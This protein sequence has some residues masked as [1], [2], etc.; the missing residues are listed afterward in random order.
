MTSD[1]AQHDAVGAFDTSAFS[2]P[3]DSIWEESM[4]LAR[5]AADYGAPPAGP[6]TSHVNCGERSMRERRM[7]IVPITGVS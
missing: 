4:H 1:K 6:T 7:K 5:L 3:S 2:P